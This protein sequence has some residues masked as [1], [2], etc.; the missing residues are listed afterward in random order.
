MAK[1]TKETF[2]SPVFSITRIKEVFF[3]LNEQLHIPEGNKAVRLEL[4][5]L[6]GFIPE[7]NIVGL[8]IRAYYHYP[9]RPTDEILTEIRVETRFEVPGLARY[10]QSENILVLPGELITEFIQ[11]S[12][13]HTRALLAQRLAGS[14]YQEIIIP[15]HDPKRI[16][17]F[18][19]PHMFNSE[20]EVTISD[21]RGDVKGKVTVKPNSVTRKSRTRK[22]G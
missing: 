4:S 1:N 13:S 11:L 14:N 6:L 12:L 9:E 15:V 21:D 10:L 5:P 18:F 16:A 22:S 2:P 19:F 8:G 20:Q 17:R 7:S 3:S